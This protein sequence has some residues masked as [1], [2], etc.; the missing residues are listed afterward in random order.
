MQEEME[1]RMGRCL[2]QKYIDGG[3]IRSALVLSL[4]IKQKRGKNN[5]MVSTGHVCSF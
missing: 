5:E 4:H 3:F 2:S 1:R